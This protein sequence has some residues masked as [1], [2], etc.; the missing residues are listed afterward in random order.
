[1]SDEKL[2]HTGLK[3]VWNS[4]FHQQLRGS[5][6]SGDGRGRSGVSQ[7]FKSTVFR[8][9][10]PDTE[11]ACSHLLDM[12]LM[13]HCSQT[14]HLLPACSLLTHTHQ[15]SLHL[16]CHCTR[17]N[18][19]RLKPWRV[20]FFF[21]LFLDVSPS[22]S[23]VYSP[24]QRYSAVVYSE[25]VLVFVLRG[26]FAQWQRD[27]EVQNHRRSGELQPE[28]PGFL[29]LLVVDDLFIILMESPITWFI[30]CCAIVRFYLPRRYKNA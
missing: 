17:F 16:V 10:S 28:T 18:V 14:Q 13:F 9:Q 5:L 7:C 25:P 30:L 2:P 21:F 4:W 19:T 12:F 27:G 29:G 6:Q 3:Q 20:V 22:V 24:P 23:G 8:L 15:E 1:M 26:F 11:A